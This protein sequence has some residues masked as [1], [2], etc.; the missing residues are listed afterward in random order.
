MIKLKNYLPVQVM[1]TVAG[2]YSDRNLTNLIVCNLY[3]I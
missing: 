1:R 3:V 2:Y